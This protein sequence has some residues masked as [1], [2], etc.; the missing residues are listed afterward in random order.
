MEILEIKSTDFPDAR[1]L[2]L[3]GG[4]PIS[5]HQKSPGGNSAL[6]KSKTSYVPRLGGKA[7]AE[8]QKADQATTAANRTVMW[9]YNGKRRFVRESEY[10]RIREEMN[11]A[12][13]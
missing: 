9:L 8:L 1:E 2:P 11:S 10:R 7:L 13:V 12:T 3:H 6:G 5:K 4:R